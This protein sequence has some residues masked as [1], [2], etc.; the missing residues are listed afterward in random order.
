MT[1][2]D[3]LVLLIIA[4][5]VIL[6]VL[7]GLV[8]ECLSIIAWVLSFLVAKL[9]SVEMAA[10][11]PASIPNASLQLLAA[12]ILLF[13]ATLLI[14]TLLGIALSKVI[15]VAG[16]GWANRLLGSL[17]GL[18]RGVLLVMML[19]ML[20]GL[21]QLPQHTAWR[22]A[23]L[24]APLEAMVNVILPWMPAALAERVTFD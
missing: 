10:L 3:Y 8:K 14:F 12:F 23:M 24:S 7:R 2:F 16:M 18:S 22:T 20:A 1:S 9:Y 19:V 4:S 13:V 17:F 21:T 6:G 11:L 15:Q 5:S